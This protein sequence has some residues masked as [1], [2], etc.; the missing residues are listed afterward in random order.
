[1]FEEVSAPA[2]PFIL[3]LGNLEPKKNLPL[4]LE[5]Y[6]I[7][8]TQGGTLRLVLAGIK[9]W[10]YKKISELAKKSPFAHDI[11]FPGY[12]STAEKWLAYRQAT[13]LVFPSLC[14]GLGFPPLEAASCGTPVLLSDL[15]VFRETLPQAYFFTSGNIEACAHAMLKIT[16][17]PHRISYDLSNFDFDSHAKKC[18]ALYREL[19]HA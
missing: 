10:G 16:A 14:E 2:S 9:N 19:L 4:L 11:E 3:Y 8:R 5:A 12:F 6:T 18:L 1:L 13:L 15:P 17:N 7:Y